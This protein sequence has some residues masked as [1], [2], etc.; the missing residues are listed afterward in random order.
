MDTFPTQMAGVKSVDNFPIVYYIDV[1]V[2]RAPRGAM[3]SGAHARKRPEDLSDSPN[4]IRIRAFYAGMVDPEKLRPRVKMALRMYAYATVPD[5]KT[6]A[7]VV[8]LNVG[9]LQNVSR[10][11]AGKAFL[12]TAQQIIADTSLSTTQLIDNLSRRAIQVIGTQMEDASSEA[13]RL[14]AAIDLADRGSETSKIQKHQVES[15]TLNSQDARA[16]AESM[17]AAASL[18]QRHVALRTENLD[19]VTVSEDAADAPVIV[20]LLKLEP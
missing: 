14:K 11:V 12:K 20:P 10:T 13:L 17:V 16:I 4:A 3:P 19:N 8:S 5:L 2:I 6:A 1:S 15:F 18:R 9:Y 7:E